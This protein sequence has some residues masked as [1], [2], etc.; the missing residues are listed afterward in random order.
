MGT[1][2]VIC[3]FAVGQAASA[4]MIPVKV[5]ALAEGTLHSMLKA[6]FKSAI[7]ELLAFALK[8][9]CLR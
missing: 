3:V 1:I 9:E 4:T 5:G 6:K 2:N 8:K 7:I